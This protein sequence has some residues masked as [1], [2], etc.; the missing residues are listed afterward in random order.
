MRFGEYLLYFCP[1]SFYFSPSTF[2]LEKPI[3]QCMNRLIPNRVILYSNL[4]HRIGLRPFF[5]YLTHV[6][7]YIDPKS[8][9]LLSVNLYIPCVLYIANVN[10][11]VCAVCTMTAFFC[12]CK[13]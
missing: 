9:I 3:V 13:R 6:Y 7:Y 12:R 5:N 11:S 1:K 8:I 2:L 10:T 4:R